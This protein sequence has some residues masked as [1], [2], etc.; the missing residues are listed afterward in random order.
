[1]VNYLKLHSDRNCS[2]SPS[3]ENVMQENWQPKN[4]SRRIYNKS[5]NS[6]SAV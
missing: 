3:E 5:W 4:A 6:F 1:M 2:R